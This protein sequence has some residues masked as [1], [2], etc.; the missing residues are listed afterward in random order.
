MLKLTWK[1]PKLTIKTLALAGL[2]IAFKVI[3][4]KISLGPE[5]LVKVSLGF[6][7]TILLGYFLGPWLAGV[8]MIL[9]DIISNTIFSSG[10][11][12]FIGFT[13]SAFLSGVIAGAFF[14][15]Q[16]VSWQ[17]VLCYEFIQCLISN[18]ILTTLWI[19]VLYSTP[20]WSLL[21]VRV[22]KNLIL[23]PIETLVG[24]IILRAISKSKLTTF[25]LD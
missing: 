10:A 20:I 23:W 17:R 22:P 5:N 13:F 3:L 9:Q 14:Y 1:S 15:Q 2:L 8:A 7:G 4:S 24:I 21:I 18:I 11:P 25:N 12:F 6:I 19:H 16:K